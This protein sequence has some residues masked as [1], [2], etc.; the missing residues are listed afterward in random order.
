MSEEKDVEKRIKKTNKEGLEKM[1][2]RREATAQKIV[3]QLEDAKKR[4]RGWNV[5]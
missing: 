1:E 4:N 2:A 3:K 5:V